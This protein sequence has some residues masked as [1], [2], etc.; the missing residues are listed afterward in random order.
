MTAPNE[1]DFAT[2][3]SRETGRILRFERHLS[4]PIDAVWAALTDSAELPK[5]FAPADIEL[6][7]GGRA[8][9]RFEGGNDI[10]DGRVIAVEP[11]RLLEYGWLEN[12]RDRGSVRWE[13]TPAPGGTQL[14]LLHSFPPSEPETLDFAG[15]WHDLL[16]S[17]AALLDGVERQYDGERWKQLK[18]EYERR[19]GPVPPLP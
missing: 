4:H 12:G 5:W 16:D 10:V 3:A 9:I 19:N 7:V 8:N 6:R 15:G 14:V 1:S 18:A 13:L 2:L 11:P 17:L